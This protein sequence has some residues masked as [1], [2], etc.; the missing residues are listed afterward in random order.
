MRRY[1]RALILASALTVAGALQGQETELLRWGFQAGDTWQYRLT[2]NTSISGDPVRDPDSGQMIGESIRQSQLQTLTL[3]AAVRQ[4]EAN[5]NATV[6]WTYTRM[7][8]STELDGTSLDWDSDRPDPGLAE[9]PLGSMIA[10]LEAM[11]GRTLTVVMTPRGQTLEVRGAEAMLAAM[12]EGL[13]PEIAPMMEE[14]LGPMFDEEQMAS[15]FT[16]GV[17]SLPEAPVASG[18]SWTTHTEVPMPMLGGDLVSEIRNSVTGF[19]NRSGERVVLILHEGT[20]ELDAP[21]LGGGLPM[22]ITLDDASLSG[23]TTFSVDRGLILN[24]T[25]TS[26]Q[27]MTMSMPAAGMR[28]R[29]RTE[30]STG[31]EL[32]GPVTGSQ[33]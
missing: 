2:Q 4:V 23:S 24:S 31:L 14:Q 30:S 33:R 25:S 17:G 26:Q 9:S 28:V 21:E 15:Q 5:G 19:D 10:P 13:P 7:Q 3:E 18:D 12:H 29:M 1:T 22:T 8:M 6:D 27:V 11:L 20:I 32:V 16:G